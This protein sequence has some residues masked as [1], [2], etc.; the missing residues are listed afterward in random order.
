MIYDTTRRYLQ[1]IPFFILNIAWMVPIDD[2]FD[3]FKKIDYL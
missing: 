3:D 2:P 1:M